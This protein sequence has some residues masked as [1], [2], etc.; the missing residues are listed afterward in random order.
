MVS[1]SRGRLNVT[2]WQSIDSG[3]WLMRIRRGSHGGSYMFA[4]AEARRLADD[5]HDALDAI[6]YN[7]RKNE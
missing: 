7:E 3:V 4:A 2:H 6:E 1:D 5:I